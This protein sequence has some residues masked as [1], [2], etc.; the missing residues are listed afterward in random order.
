V[1]SAG[2]EL[3]LERRFLL[4]GRAKTGRVSQRIDAAGRSFRYLRAERTQG[5]DRLV[6]GLVHLQ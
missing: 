4:E 6:S 1:R 3:I 5:D 2:M